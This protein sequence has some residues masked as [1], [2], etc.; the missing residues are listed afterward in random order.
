MRVWQ[1]IY[2]M[3]L[4]VCI[5]F[6]NIGIYAVFELVYR[7]N[8]ET[9][10]VRSEVDYT[11]ISESIRSNMNAMY[12]QGRLSDDTAADL[13]GIYEKQ[14][15]K[16]NMNMKL[17][18]DEE[19][20]YPDMGQKIPF[21]V[22][23][24]EVRIVISGSRKQKVLEIISEM[25]GFPNRYH[26]YLS[27]PLSELNAAWNRLFDIYIYISLGISLVLALILNVMLRILLRPI[28][29]LAT[30]V[31]NIEDGDYSSR[32]PVKGNDEFSILGENINLMA[33]TIER[34]INRLRE[35]NEKKEQLVDN[36]AHEMKSPLT[37][38]YGFAEY[39][40]KKIFKAF[41]LGLY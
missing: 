39:L 15:G 30:G 36:L 32:I 7:K 2:L 6:V 16:Q 28:K 22:K 11:A 4:V 21:C 37:S 25:Q 40:I 9:E 29:E 35:D 14:H 33:E 3:V 1:K 8:I 17:W 41:F 27:Y 34:N 38:I 19:Q 18:R 24:G 31:S 10:Q 26:L 20:I 12:E 23:K 13:I 5:L